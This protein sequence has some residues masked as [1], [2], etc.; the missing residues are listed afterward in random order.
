MRSDHVHPCLYH[1][2]FAIVQ[3]ASR[4]MFYE[5]LYKPVVSQRLRQ[6]GHRVA[7]EHKWR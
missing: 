5:V 6:V 4:L 2:Y 7:K 3:V 1:L